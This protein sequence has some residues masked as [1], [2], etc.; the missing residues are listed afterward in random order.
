MTVLSNAWLFAAVTVP[1]TLATLIIWW[2][3]VRLQNYHGGAHER[4][5]SWRTALR[6]YPNSHRAPE[7]IH[8]S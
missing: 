8:L 3:W 5:S 7:D 1:L 4:R 6:Y 2:L